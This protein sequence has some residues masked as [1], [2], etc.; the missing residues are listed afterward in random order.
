MCQVQLEEGAG[1]ELQVGSL[2]GTGLLSAA[3]FFIKFFFY[4]PEQ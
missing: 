4:Y 3:P 2:T 1:E